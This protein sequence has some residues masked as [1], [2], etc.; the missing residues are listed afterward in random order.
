MPVIKLL[1]SADLNQKDEPQ[2][3]EWLITLK[4]LLTGDVAFSFL[5]IGICISAAPIFM[6]GG[7]TSLAW[8]VVLLTFVMAMLLL[9]LKLV[10]PA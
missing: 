5:M 2:L 6:S 8:P 3:P 7:K 1:V 10:F 9:V 4:Q